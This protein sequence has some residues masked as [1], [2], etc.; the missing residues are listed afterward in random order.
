MWNALQNKIETWEARQRRNVHGQGMCILGKGIE[1]TT[2]HLLLT[3]FFHNKYWWTLVT[4]WRFEICKLRILLKTICMHDL[5]TLIP[6]Y[7]EPFCFWSFGKFGYLEMVW[8][9]PQ[10]FSFQVY[11]WVVAGFNYYSK[12][13]NPTFSRLVGNVFIDKRTC[14]GFFDLLGIR[15][16]IW[17][18][19]PFVLL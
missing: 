6:S 13:T 14:Y 18:G 17:V 7:L 1:E 2:I 16:Y 12:D 5:L 11:S 4:G 15:P 3:A 19:S 8:Y 10:M 9:L